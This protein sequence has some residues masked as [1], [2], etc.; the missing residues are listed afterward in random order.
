[1]KAVQ[2][3]ICNKFDELNE[4]EKGTWTWK[5]VC[6]IGIIIPS[7]CKEWLIEYAELYHAEQLA[8]SQPKKNTAEEILT[9][10]FKHN[11]CSEEFIKAEINRFINCPKCK[12]AMSE[13]QSKPISMSSDDYYNRDKL[14]EHK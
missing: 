3:F 8:E 14:F 4:K 9:A 11:N 6:A 10:Y 12:N 1:M 7:T 5:Q 2:E 13:S